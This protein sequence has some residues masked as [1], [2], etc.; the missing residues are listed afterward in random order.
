MTALDP[1]RRLAELK[2]LHQRF[3]DLRLLPPEIG[4]TALEGPLVVDGEE[5]WIRVS[6]PPGYPSVPPEVR[7]LEGPRGAAVPPR[8][9]MHRFSDGTLCLFRH[10][11]HAETWRHD[12]LAVEAVERAI[13]LFRRERAGEKLSVRVMRAPFRVVIPPGAAV[14]FAVPQ[15][16]GTLITRRSARGRGDFFVDAIA[17][18]RVEQSIQ[19]VLT[20]SWRAA[21]P[22]PDQ[23]FWLRAPLPEDWR[24]RLRGSAALDEMLAGA[25]PPALVRRFHDAPVAVLVRERE[26]RELD[27]LVIFRPKEHVGSLLISDVVLAAPGDLMFH[28]LAG[29]VR[30]RA[31]LAEITVIFAGLGSLGGAIALALARVG[32]GSFVLIDPDLVEPENLCRHVA[33][34]ADLGDFKVT[35]LNRKIRGINPDAR[36]QA[37]AKPLAWDRPEFGAGLELERLI[38]GGAKALLVST[39]AEPHVDRQVNA[40][41][42]RR[43][44]P[45]VFAAALGAAEH[46]RIF[47][48]LPGESA[49]YACVWATQNERP[50]D[51]PRFALPEAAEVGYA[52]PG[53]PG[54]GIDVAQIATLAAR[55]ALQTI[56]RVFGLELGFEDESADHLLW[57]NRG[58]WLFDRPLQLCALRF[59]RRDDCPVCGPPTTSELSAEER[60]ELEGLSASMRGDDE[61]TKR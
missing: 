31:K 58:G 33:E 40:L 3:G 47:R 39:C 10:G 34:V 28:R 1:K 22:H 27:A 8:G 18:E 53:L 54:L 12:R 24:A 37:I 61:R 2:A 48:V 15:G 46:G 50:D 41:A 11:S 45:A 17:E 36:V 5:R 16:R 59:P 30:D 38:E 42:V 21:L 26:G 20:E 19:N 7:E 23:L 29:L 44:V 14:L 25:V 51:F 6:L 13:E 57:T 56:G 52:Q 43:G 4:V 60:D 32:I 9:R 35:A 49:C 55:L